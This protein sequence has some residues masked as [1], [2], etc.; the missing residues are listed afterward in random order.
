MGDLLMPSD[1]EKREGRAAPGVPAQQPLVEPPSAKMV[2]RLFLIP[3]LVAAAVVGI[4]LPIGCLTE[5]PVSLETAITRLKNPGGERTLGMVGPGSKQ[6]YMDAKAVV[7]HMKGGLNEEQRIKLAADV[8]EILDHHTKPEEG[9]VQQLMLLV[10]GR[11]WQINPQ[12]PPMN[13]PEAQQSRQRVVDVL[14]NHFDAQH[15][16]A[17]KAAILSL[18]FWDGRE[19]ARRA[20]PKLVQKLEDEREDVD[21]RMAA[22]VT[23]GNIGSAN[24]QEVIAALSSAMRETDERNAEISW[25]A[26]LALARFNRPEATGTIMKL[27]SREELSQMRVYDRESDPQN[28]VFRKLTELEQQRFLTN[29]MEWAKHLQVPEVQAQLKKIIDTDPSARVRTAGLETLSAQRATTQ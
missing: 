27:L 23:L 15:V 9:D 22:A 7:D 21:V 2:V 29:A 10:L 18:R 13:S 24:D 28:P 14:I 5:G 20:I 25:N 1:V 4:M 6:R 12:Q 11:V 26:A 3:L 17:R 8:V 19:E 16:Q